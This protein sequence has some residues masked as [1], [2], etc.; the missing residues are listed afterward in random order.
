MA[1]IKN[2]ALILPRIAWV[3]DKG[4]WLVML[5][6]NPSGKAQSVTQREMS[7]ACRSVRTEISNKERKIVYPSHHSLGKKSTSNTKQ[8]AVSASIKG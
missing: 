7:I 6:I 8:S 1:P 3:S 4:K 2:P 5:K